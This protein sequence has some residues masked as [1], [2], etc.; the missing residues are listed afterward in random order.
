MHCVH[1]IWR[2]CH[3]IQHMGA[4]F[5]QRRHVIIALFDAAQDSRCSTSML[6]FDQRGQKANLMMRQHGAQT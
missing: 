1:R 4:V 5:T 3:G 2:I 6:P